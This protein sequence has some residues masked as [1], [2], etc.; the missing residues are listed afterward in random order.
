MPI[1]LIYTLP[2]LRQSG[3]ADFFSR[4][5]TGLGLV[6]LGLLLCW[7]S[8]AAF[9]NNSL[10][11]MLQTS[12]N[13][14]RLWAIAVAAILLPA[15]F[16]ATAPSFFL[17]GG[18]QF[19]F[20]YVSYKAL[21]EPDPS[22]R[23]RFRLTQTSEAIVNKVTRPPKTRIDF[24]SAVPAGFLFQQGNFMPLT[25]DYSGVK[26]AVINVNGLAPDQII[27]PHLRSDLGDKDTLT[28]VSYPDEENAQWTLKTLDAGVSFYIGPPL[29][30]PLS[31]LLK[32]FMGLA[33]IGAWLLLVLSLVL[34]AGVRIV[35]ELLT[36]KVKDWL[37]A[38]FSGG[39][40][41]APPASV[42]RPSSS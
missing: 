23:D 21:L 17:Q 36:D 12:R 34:I 15:V 7:V 2:E 9:T 31:Q 25:G 8:L 38:R 32:P 42:D 20:R 29:P 40:R 6:V 13:R 14:P 39:K 37:K 3:E 4:P 35:G 26:N 1:S 11:I 10:A 41:S 19:A 27:V 5:I 18:G 16:Y 30:G 24:V 28:T 22:N 33:S